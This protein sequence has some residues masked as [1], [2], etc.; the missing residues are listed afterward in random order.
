MFF[1]QGAFSMTGRKPMGRLCSAFLKH[2]LFYFKEMF[3]CKEKL[4]LVICKV[5]GFQGT[6]ISVF[7]GSLFI[8]KSGYNQ[9]LRCFPQ[10][11]FLRF[12][13]CELADALS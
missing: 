12:L 11:Y 5:G 2:F 6:K 4:R 9:L 7:R 8:D 3:H 1:R 10:N 13:A